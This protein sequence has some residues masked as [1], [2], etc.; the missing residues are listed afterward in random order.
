MQPLYQEDII[1]I[2][3]MVTDNDPTIFGIIQGGCIL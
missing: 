3:R 2:Y 1:T